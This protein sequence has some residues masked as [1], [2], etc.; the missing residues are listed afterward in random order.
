MARRAFDVVVCGGGV[1]GS[2]TAFFLK[3]LAPRL[4]VAVVERDDTYASASSPLS[5]GGIR[6]QFSNAENV[7]LSMV[8]AHVCVRARFSL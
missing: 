2:A 6:Q 8:C 7:A 1:M 5:V 3:T 4:A